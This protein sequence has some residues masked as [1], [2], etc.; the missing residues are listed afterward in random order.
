ML[1]FVAWLR[2][3]PQY[4]RILAARS[5]SMQLTWLLFNRLAFVCFHP[6]YER[7]PAAA[8]EP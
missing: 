1:T 4:A 3:W 7:L 8:A 5:L 6:Q 2:P